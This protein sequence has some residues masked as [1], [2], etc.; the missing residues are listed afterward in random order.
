M[1]IATAFRGASA[2]LVVATVSLLAWP[3]VTHA[4]LKV[5]M[6]TVEY[7]EVELEH[8]GLMTFGPRGSSFDRSQ[9]YTN[10]IAY[11]I[12]P[13]W[14]I[15]VESS[16]A[17]GAGQ[18]LRSDAFAFENTFQLTEPGEYFVNLGFFA[19]YEHVMVRGAPNAVTL[20][21]IIQKELPSFL[22]LNTLH[23]A[24][25]FFTRDIGANAGR[26]IGFT[27]AWQSVVRLMPLLAPGIEFFGQIE[28]LGQAGHYNQQ[29]HL[30]GPVVT[31]EQA[32]GGLGELKYEVGYLFGVTTNSPTGAVRWRLE[33]DIAF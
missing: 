20:G 1:P 25:L 28:S 17:A 9:S 4:E 26:A 8:N 6:P 7:Q 29:Q 11:G 3:G 12:T 32:L 13:W 21:P 16:V 24:N 10:E 2:I 30:V 15:E 27:Y 18:S 22:G 33:Y 31:G 23:T 14:Q 5:R 19:G